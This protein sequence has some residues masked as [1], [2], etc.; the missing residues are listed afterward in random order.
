MPRFRGSNA[1]R[2]NEKKSAKMKAIVRGAGE[3]ASLQNVNILGGVVIDKTKSRRLRGEAIS[4]LATIAQSGGPGSMEALE[5][6]KTV[7]E[8][9]QHPRLKF[10]AQGALIK[11]GQ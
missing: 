11:L 6:L 4:S 7:A 9:L 8:S 5:T 1:R 10:Q 2:R 3:N